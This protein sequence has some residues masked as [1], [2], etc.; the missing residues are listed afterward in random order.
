MQT[1]LDKIAE[2]A[3]T[4][5]NERFTSLYH[6]LNEE[7][8]RACHKEAQGRRAPGIDGETKA[9]Y[10]VNLD[11]NLKDLVNRLRTFGYHP[12]PALRVN[13]PKGNGETRPLGISTYEDKLVQMG[14]SKIL[15]AIYEQDFIEDSYGFRPDRDCHDALRAITQ[16]LEHHP[17]NFI[18][19]ADIK[20]FFNHVN[21]E[22]LIKF[23]EHRI[24]DP[25][26]IRLIK[27][28]LRAGVIEQGDYKETEEGTPQGSSVS[29]ILANIYLHYVLDL[30]FEK[31]VKQKAR[32]YAG[33]VRYADD[34]ICCF[35][36]VKD[37]EDFMVVLRKRLEKFGLELAE[38]KSR[39]VEFGRFADSNNK[40]KGVKT[41][42]FDFLGFM[43]Y[44]GKSR[45]G[46]FRVKRKTSKKKYRV[47][48][49]EFK[50]WIKGRRNEVKMLVI[51]DEVKAKLEEH[52][53]Y[54]GITDNSKMLETFYKNIV[55]LT[56]KW[57][58]RR[59]QRKSFDWHSFNKYLR[60][61][62]L[63]KPRVLHSV[64][65]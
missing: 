52:F 48:V 53:Q 45:N 32:G 41:Q 37:A 17:T 18:V 8:L 10:D 33:M 2:V 26:I 1:K 11:D 56:F 34:F 43:H 23:L 14:L 7:M 22:W 59:S 64:Y 55:E 49:A 57:L 16:Q 5:G 27:R 65:S 39:I 47:K 46:K 54:F 28:M 44:C 6:L 42:T 30:W 60:K 21:H 38:E 51:M 61:Y 62:P 4:K 58:N 15:N 3:R 35:Y 36:H 19:E 63:P 9:S 50:E 31:G 13:I 40:K 12:Q 20:G 29:P 25:N 24:A